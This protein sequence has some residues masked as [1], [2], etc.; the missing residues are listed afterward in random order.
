MI[1]P[2]ALHIARP[3]AIAAL[4]IAG[5]AGPGAIAAHALA[6]APVVRTAMCAPAAHAPM[7]AAMGSACTVATRGGVMHVSM[8]MARGRG[9]HGMGHGAA[10]GD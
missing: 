10:R 1:N 6:P 9:V 5:V 4:A 7:R 3:V 2:L 8:P